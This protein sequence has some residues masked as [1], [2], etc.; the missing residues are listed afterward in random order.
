[1]T[2]LNKSEIGFVIWLGWWKCD[3]QREGGD[4]NNVVCSILISLIYP[5]IGLFS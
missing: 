3:N 2:L 5:H 1:M 4:I